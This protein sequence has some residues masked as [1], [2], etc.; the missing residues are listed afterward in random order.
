MAIAAI[1][2]AVYLTL[3]LRALRRPAPGSVPG[4]WFGTVAALMWDD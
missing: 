1:L 2:L 3:G 4:L